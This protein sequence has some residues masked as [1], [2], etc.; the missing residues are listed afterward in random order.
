MTN[1][2]GQDKEMIE[3]EIL[4]ETYTLKTETGAEYT[5]RVAEHVDRTAREIRDESGVVDQKKVA[6]L[7]AIAVTDQ[8]FRMRDGVET[9]KG[10][11][12][13]RAERLIGEILAT[14]EQ[15]AGD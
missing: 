10:L 13:K 2:A 7:T 12:E 15:A 4:G 11:A 3:V 1:G 14:V 8:L 6:I 9:V 5:R